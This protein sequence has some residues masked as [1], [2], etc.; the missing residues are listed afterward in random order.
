MICG[1]QSAAGGAPID[2]RASPSAALWLV[3]EAVDVAKAVGATN[4][5]VRGDS[6]FAVG[7]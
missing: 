4:I 6:T 1:P 2:D 3:T 5:L 7:G